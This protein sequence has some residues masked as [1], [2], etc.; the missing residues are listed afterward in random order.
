MRS[1]LVFDRDRYRAA[2]RSGHR[3]LE[4]LRRLNAIEAWLELPESTAIAALTMELRHFADGPPREERARQYDGLFDVIGLKLERDAHHASSGHEQVPRRQGVLAELRVAA[5]QAFGGSPAPVRSTSGLREAA[6]AIEARTQDIALAF[7]PG[8]P[9][10]KEHVLR[11]ELAIADYAALEA[12]AQPDDPG[13]ADLRWFAGNSA[14]IL[15][16]AFVQLGQYPDARRDFEKAA[17]FFERAYDRRN[18]IDCR[19]RAEDLGRDLAADFD[20]K[21]EASLSA[22][23]SSPVAPPV[24]LGV[25]D[26]SRAEVLV[27]LAES[28]NAVG[29]VFDADRSANAA[30]KEL[31]RAGFDDPIRSPVDPASA[32]AVA[33]NLSSVVDS[34]IATASVSLSGLAFI[35]C[36]LKVGQFYARIAAARLSMWIQPD[37]KPDRATKLA[38]NAALA[39][40][41]F[42]ELTDLLEEMI[43]EG[44]EADAQVNRELGVYFPAMAAAVPVKPAGPSMRELRALDKAILDIQSTCNARIEAGE[45][46]DDLLDAAD[47]CRGQAIALGIPLYEV[48]AL[49]ARAYVTSKKRQ[50]PETMAAAREASRVLLAGRASTLASL[51]QSAERAYYLEARTRELDGHTI[52]GEHEQVLAFCESTVRD[53]EAQRGRVNSP[54][55]ESTFLYSALCFYRIGAFAAFKLQRWEALLALSELVKARSSV[56]SVLAQPAADE[57]PADVQR[58][59][60]MFREA[61]TTDPARRRWLWDMLSI[62]RHRAQSSA[63][64]PTLTVAALQARLDPDEAAIGYFWLS[65]AVLLVLL[66]DRER[67][68][69]ERVILE[70]RD[71]KLLNRLAEAFKNLVHELDRPI[72]QLGALLFPPV[73]QEFVAKKRRLVFSP[74][75]I[76]HLFPFH[77]VPYEGAFI[78]TRFAVRYAP[79]FGSLLIPWH[80]RCENRALAIAVRDCGL[81]DPIAGGKRMSV[82]DNVEPEVEQIRAHYQARGVPVDVLVGDDASRDTLLRMSAKGELSRYRYV[83][84]G[85]HGK[86]LLESANDPMEAELFMRLSRLDSMDVAGLG[87]RAEVAMMSAC[88][89]GQRA[90]KGRGL[91]ELPGDEIF[92]LQSALFQSGVHAVVGTLW[93]VIVEAASVVVPSFHAALAAGDAPDVALQSAVAGY[94]RTADESHRGVAFWAPFFLS[95]VGTR[96][97]D[98]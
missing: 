72:A 33:C 82:L 80:S 70:P 76:L 92:G 20:A 81:T 10:P 39:D 78:G 38:A 22:L 12:S 42:A 7:A 68:R 43:T 32:D 47:A 31:V 94:L 25:V 9:P 28:Q 77:A 37:S 52:A 83:H 4:A 96:S 71:R 74:N 49:L 88:H 61:S 48:K 44:A 51:P 3:Q 36:M 16:R 35:E 45:A 6:L 18:A 60:T 75:L 63:P 55:Q 5:R 79:N 15:A 19:R 53:F 73:C 97:V 24:G 90:V 67:F 8:K 27:G 13:L 11:L 54:F 95:C 26:L 14:F 98:A 66:V 50:G 17:T 56:R 84:L 41:V 29:D 21:I 58:L 87:I 89:S 86:S 85:T 91:S 30:A 23:V 46:V 57:P 65:D 59:E 62:A 64:A 69:V 1:D 2:V 34:W 93:P 40:L